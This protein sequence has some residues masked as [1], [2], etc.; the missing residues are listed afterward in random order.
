MRCLLEIKEVSKSFK[1]DKRKV[2]VLND[3]SFSVKKREFV[4][5]VGPSGC[6][7][8]TLLSLIAG[9][10]EYDE[11]NIYFKGEKVI[12]PSPER[13][14]VFQDFN[15]LFPWKTVIE[16]VLFPLNVNKK[17]TT[18]NERKDL[19]K[20]YLKMVKLEGYEDYYPNE[21]SG[22]M[23]QRTAIARALIMKPEI[24]LMDEPFGSLDAQTRMQLQTTLIELLEEIETTIVFVTHDIEEAVVL[25]DRII[26]LGKSSN[27]I[28]DVMVNNLDRP[29]DRLSNKFI[30]KVK[31]VYDKI[32]E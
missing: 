12:A 14:M 22:G 20:K 7:K 30:E 1:K 16:N 21:I 25:S 9:F 31:K 19:A 17:E 6:G 23:K 5:V 2:K 13:V 15:Q 26:A 4:S 3:V 32:K 11:G 18:L 10:D 29:R 28:K 27:S 24:L 8:S